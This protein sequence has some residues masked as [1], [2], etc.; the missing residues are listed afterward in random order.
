M[1]QTPAQSSV[2]KLSCSQLLYAGGWVLETSKDRD[3]MISLSNLLQ[4]L[5][6]FIVNHDASAELA[7]NH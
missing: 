7:T 1:V 6:V 5:I 3:C 4:W 2:I